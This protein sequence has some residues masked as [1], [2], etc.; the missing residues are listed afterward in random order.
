MRYAAPM[1]ATVT[2]KGNGDVY[3]VLDW[4]TDTE[5]EDIR[6]GTLW[7]KDANG[8]QFSVRASKV[9]EG[10]EYTEAA[11]QPKDRRA[12]MT[13]AMDAIAAANAAA[14]R[15]ENRRSYYLRTGR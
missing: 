3:L 6:P 13:D 8:T 1:S 15:K 4:P 12:E 14:D 5:P 2:S 7:V 10:G 11:P 9:T